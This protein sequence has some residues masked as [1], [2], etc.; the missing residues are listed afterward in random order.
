MIVT[1]FALAP[2]PFIYSQQ[3]T[4]IKCL[5][6]FFFAT[7][8]SFVASLLFFCYWWGILKLLFF[9]YRRFCSFIFC[10]WVV[11]CTKWRQWDELQTNKRVELPDGKLASQLAS[12]LC[13]EQTLRLKRYRFQH[14]LRWAIIARKRVKSFSNYLQFIKIIVSYLRLNFNY[15]YRLKQ[16]KYTSILWKLWYIKDFF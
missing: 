9:K 12:Q 15:H 16:T 3:K 7:S 13:G 8:K 14:S 1:A 6:R 5:D 2:A 10:V 11:V 4:A